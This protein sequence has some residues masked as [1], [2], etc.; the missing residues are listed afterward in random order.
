MH[1]FI[2]YDEQVYKCCT[3][4]RLQPTVVNKYLIDLT[5]SVR[6]TERSVLNN[7]ICM[8]T[9]SSD[10]THQSSVRRGADYPGP[11]KPESI[12]VSTYTV[13][14]Q[15]YGLAQCGSGQAAVGMRVMMY[16]AGFLVSLEFQS[17]NAAAF[18]E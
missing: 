11:Y 2:A 4:R 10:L 16:L 1:I 15:G 7:V 14:T 18:A 8:E 3:L 17:G 6:I 12:V 9:V 13:H 5:T